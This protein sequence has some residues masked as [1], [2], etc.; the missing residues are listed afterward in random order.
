MIP[1]LEVMDQLPYRSRQRTGTEHSYPSSMPHPQGTSK[2]SGRYFD[3]KTGNHPY[4]EYISDDESQEEEEENV[5]ESEDSI[6]E[7]IPRDQF[8]TSLAS[9]SDE[10]YGQDV[11]RE[12]F[13]TSPEPRSVHSSISDQY[14]KRSKMPP[15]RA[16]ASQRYRT[17][18]PPLSEYFENAETQGTFT[19]AAPTP[20]N[21]KQVLLRPQLEADT[22]GEQDERLQASEGPPEF[23]EDQHK[24]SEGQSMG[25]ATSV[26]GNYVDNVTDDGNHVDNVADDGNQQ[27]VVENSRGGEEDSNGGGGGEESVVDDAVPLVTGS[28]EQ[29]NTGDTQT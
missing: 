3:P 16:K 18:H 22:G 21:L 5:S 24:E 1:R 25:E 2:S 27:Q 15:A 23:E 17:H 13:E 14:L 28:N 29:D 9:E 26:H 8:E 20:D 11:P 4:Q 7:D 6:V 10:E 19:S 12:Q